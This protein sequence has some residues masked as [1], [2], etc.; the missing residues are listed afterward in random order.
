MAELDSLFE[1]DP[2]ELS[3]ADIDAIIARFRSDRSRF[4]MGER[5]AAKRPAKAKPGEN[6]AIDL[7]DLLS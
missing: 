1:R 7:E 5:P 2:T 3:S 6:I 4:N